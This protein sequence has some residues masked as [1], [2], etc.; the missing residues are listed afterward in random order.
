MLSGDKKKEKHEE[1]KYDKL[2]SEA[3]V[4]DKEEM[5]LVTKRN[6]SEESK[7]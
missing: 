1:A 3:N 5:E 2:D 6:L 4:I 7:D